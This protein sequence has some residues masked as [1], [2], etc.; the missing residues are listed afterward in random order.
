[1]NGFD[2]PGLSGDAAFPRETGL[3]LVGHGTREAV[4]VE[5]FLQTAAQVAELAGATPVEPCFLEFAEPTIAEGFQR[6]VERSATRIVV[7]PVLLFAAGHARRD[8]PLAVAEVSSKFPHVEVTQAA[9]LGCHANLLELSSLRY[10]SALIGA[11]ELVGDA[12]T[13]VLVGRGSHDADATAEMHR[14]ASLRGETRERQAARV[15]VGF[16]AMA[17]PRFTDVLEAAAQAPARRVVIQPHLLF[18]GVLLDRIAHTAAEFAA[19]Y[20]S[21]QWLAAPHL[22]PHP[23]VAAAILSRA[24]ETLSAQP[25]GS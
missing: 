6:L 22:G 14:F 1:M 17:T 4:G 3:L 9:H 12:T 15:E 13:L 24:A 23:L 25:S 21:Q 18:G 7:V 8:I 20:P 16:V 2:S 10:Q 5:E 11:E 19:R